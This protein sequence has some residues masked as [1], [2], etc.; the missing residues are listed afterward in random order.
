MVWLQRGAGSRCSTRSTGESI[1]SSTVGL[2][3]ASTA[4]SYVSASKGRGR[5]M[6]LSWNACSC[7]RC[8]RHLFPRSFYAGLKQVPP[9]SQPTF[10]SSLSDASYHRSEI[11]PDGNTLIYSAAFDGKPVELFTSHL[12]VRVQLAK[13]QADIQSISS[14]GEMVILL[15][16]ELDPFGC[17]NGTLRGC[18]WLEARLARSWSM[19]TRL[20]GSGRAGARHSAC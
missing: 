19:F 20:T 15:D 9:P 8:Y 4:E 11:L 6:Q 10:A 1:D 16:C 7:D 18:R 13:L 14:T 2:T 5:T 17:Y 12:E 3:N